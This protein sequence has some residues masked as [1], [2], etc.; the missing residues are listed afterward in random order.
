MK[1]TELTVHGFR[2]FPPEEETF[3]FNGNNVAIIGDN[4]TGKSSVLAA[5]EFLLCGNCTH[6]GGP[7]TNEIDVRTH[8]PHHHAS[9]DECY[10]TGTFETADG[11]EGTVRRVASNP[12]NLE[13]V[14]GDLDSEEVNVSQNNNDHLILTRTQLLEFIESPPSDRGNQ[15]SKLLNLS[16]L[17]NRS[18]GFERVESYI[19]R[20][21]EEKQSSCRRLVDDI[22]ESLDIDVEFPVSSDDTIL[23][24]DKI[25]HNLNFLDGGEIE[26]LDDLE[27]AMESIELEVRGEVRDTFYQSSTHR[28]IEDFQ[29]SAEEAFENVLGDLELISE[30]LG[31]LSDYEL[32]SI[33]AL[34]FYNHAERLVDSDTETCPLCGEDHEC[35]Y[36][37][38]RIQQRQDQ[39]SHI[40][41]LMD[42]VENI[43]DRLLSEIGEMISE[44]SELIDQLHTGLD[45]GD[46]ASMYDN[47]EI[48]EQF[49]EDADELYSQINQAII[50]DDADELRIRKIEYEGELPSWTDAISSSGDIHDYMDSLEPREDITETHADLV[51]VLDAWTELSETKATLEPLRELQ[52]EMAEV[53][54][55]YAEARQE[56]LSGLYRSIEG[57]FN[58]YY[59]TIH[60][61]ED[62]IDLTLDVEGTDSVD[63]EATHGEKRDNPLAYH[64]EGHIDTMGICLFLALRE[65]LDTSTADLVMLDD[66]IMS[67][68]KNHRRG[69]VRMLGNYFDDGTQAIFATHDEVWAD[70]LKEQAIVPIDNFVTIADWDLAT[71][72]IL[73]WGNWDLVQR[74]LDEDKPH[75]AA[76]H[77]RRIAEKIGRIG[78][79]RLEV[80]ITFKDRY[81]LAD[82]IYGISGKLQAHAKAT[83]DEETDGSEMWEIARDFDNDR[84]DLLG[85]FGLEELN[86][87]VHYNRHAW[88][89]L[90]A[91]DLQDVLD[92]WKQI[93]EF[94]ICSDCGSMLQ[95]SEDGN[96]SWIY[97]DGRHIEVGY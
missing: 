23:I 69:V 11:V 53:R 41:E 48:L 97:C 49:Q 28:R 34:G 76:A 58:E 21:A 55:L 86:G 89:Q 73:D 65:E 27:E 81:S 66:I 31:E 59:T 67:V 88:G 57:N 63:L 25:N 56:C 75:E 37:I 95:Y 82:Y 78:C 93:E 18:K 44:V 17:R 38:D 72:P 8:A 61:D 1:L 19:G 50:D 83:K 77:M 26:L 12:T 68:D 45:Y 92:H 40:Q 42:E 4:G 54:E 3:E 22:S 70:Q 5:I 24:L 20:K 14:S 36:L 29:V 7:G 84:K 79:I 15:L 32:Q 51:R 74:K 16:G 85:D 39:L 43:Q 62:E 6:L 10:V 71:G 47:I 60:P 13:V 91:A 30:K 9:A 94:L 80:S 64:S 46:H 90:S 96:W 52:A 35:G 2:A 33:Q 87:M